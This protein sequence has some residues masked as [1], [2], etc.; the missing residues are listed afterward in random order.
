MHHRIFMEG[1]NTAISDYERNKARIYEEARQRAFREAARGPYLAV[2]R[3]KGYQEGYGAGY[4]EGERA[5][6]VKASNVDEFYTQADVNNARRE[7]FSEGVFTG[8]AQA[9]ASQKARGGTAEDF[10]REKAID[11]MLDQCR[12]ISESNPSMA[13]GVNAVRHRIKKLKKK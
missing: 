4:K 11:E 1:Y 6:M 9:R 5:G 10:D 2:A 8:R 7:G 3:Q 12:I 13:P